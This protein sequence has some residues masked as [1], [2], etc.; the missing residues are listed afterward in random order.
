MDVD[1]CLILN[2]EIRKDR[3]EKLKNFRKM[4]E[5]KNKTCEKINGIDYKD[6]KNIIE[7]FLMNK[8]LH[9]YGT[10]FR[11]N[12]KHSRLLYTDL[13]GLPRACLKNYFK[14]HHI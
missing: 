4:W 8:R 9:A 3:W 13:T 7:D 6:K 5:N 11:S 14:K 12:K 10:G 1:N 2:L